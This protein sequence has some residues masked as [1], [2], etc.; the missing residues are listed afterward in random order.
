MK[1]DKTDIKDLE[2]DLIILR[3][4][5]LN[6]H[7]NKDERIRAKELIRILSINERLIK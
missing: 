6:F 4:L 1:Y 2:N 7:L 3:Q 5:F